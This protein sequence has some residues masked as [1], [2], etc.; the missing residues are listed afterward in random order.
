MPCLSA[1]LGT[2]CSGLDALIDN[3][4]PTPAGKVWTTGIQLAT[5]Q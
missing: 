2:A 5:I 1:G 3:L 4:L